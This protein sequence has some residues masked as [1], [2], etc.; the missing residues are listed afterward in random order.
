M[1]S[2][3]TVDLSK[4]T[5]ISS[6]DPSSAAPTVDMSK[7]QPIAQPGGGGGL[8]DWAERNLAG[9]PEEQAQGWGGGAGSA[10]AGFVKSAG[11][12]A[13]GVLDMV[14]RPKA[15]AGYGVGMQVNGR[16]AT[17]EEIQQ[18]YR[19]EYAQ[20]PGGKINQHLQDAAKWLRSGS[21][22]E[23]FWEHVGAIGEQVL[24]YIG[25]DGLLKIAGGAVAARTAAAGTKG[26]EAAE[27][28][29][30]AQQVATAL[31]SNPKLAGLVAIGLKASKDATLMAGQTYLHTEDPQQA[32]IAGVFGAGTSAAAGGLQAL[33]EKIAPRTLTIAGE[34]TPALASQVNEAGEPI[35][36]GARGAPAIATAQ[37]AAA[38]NV[39]RNTAAQATAAALGKINQSRPV[40]EAT[41]D[42]SRM[43]GAGEGAEPFRFTLEGTG[44]GETPTGE[45]A[46]PAA[47]APSLPGRQ[48]YTSESAPA[49]AEGTAP[50]NQGTMGA[51]LT[52]EP[53]RPTS[54]RQPAGET[55]QGGANLQT[56]DPMEAES[57]LRQ[58]EDLQGTPEYARMPATQQA[59]VEAQRK[60]LQEQ[61]GIYHASPYSQRFAPVDVATAT[62]GVRTFGDAAAQIEAA[63]KPVY[64]TLDR[65]SG[66]EFNKW[67][68]AAKQAQ[69]VMRSA[70]SVESYDS[71][72]ARLK[73][74]QGEISDL[75]DRHRGQVSFGDYMTAKNA[76]RDASRLDELHTN[77]ERMM[78][79]V[80]MEESDQG[81]TR[82]MT[83]RAKQL[84]RY[85]SQGTNREQI[86]A[87][88]GK[89]GVTNLKRITV[90][91]AGANT[92]RTTHQVA[93][94]VALELGR[95]I[96][97]GGWSAMAGAVG[98]GA[99]AHAMGVSPY[100]GALGG[101][102]GTRYVLR[103][104]ATS[105]RVG[106]MV[107]YA[108]RNGLSAQHYA[109]LIARALAEPLEHPETD[110]ED[111]PQQQGETQ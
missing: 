55:V 66:G 93:G 81:L 85:L 27:E 104:A 100:W 57:W 84:E 13:G 14:T 36:T 69:K 22:P 108:V 64:A 97:G 1:N 23:G 43:L 8:G 21:E 2:T 68:E 107:E 53:V 32:A 7:A 110:T 30:N 29:K 80:T 37:Q 86:E 19:Q 33:L 71:A 58:L 63:A 105:P 89:E 98:G 106:N 72:A 62:A 90:L 16:P 91:L 59:A 88:I 73:E 40:F 74:A 39:L 15:P 99:I 52:T 77:F 44:T 78:N 51:D 48:V 61:L 54:Q 18:S 26:V 47:K 87:L 10:L 46:H 20:T 3:V 109:P 17:D 83:G 9:T 38:K 11:Q 102:I 75:I 70:T 31:K 35:E 101:A 94:N 45:I 60:A 41:Q 49:V 25:T 76:W 28:L 56:T 5:P 24:E 42:A 103:M 79:G 34:Q 82:V 65:A 92:A 111:Q 4:A 67:K 6:P 12:L 50:R 95:H 96:E